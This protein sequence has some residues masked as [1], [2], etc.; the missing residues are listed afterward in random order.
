M[1]VVVV[2]KEWLVVNGKEYKYYQTVIKAT[3]YHS[4]GMQAVMNDIYYTPQHHLT[5]V[6]KAM[7]ITARHPPS[8]HVHNDILLMTKLMIAKL[9]VI[10]FWI[11]LLQLIMSFYVRGGSRSTKQQ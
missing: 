4:G 8:V 9:Y 7:S 1:V 6:I 5:N 2:L 10:C 11:S 3:C